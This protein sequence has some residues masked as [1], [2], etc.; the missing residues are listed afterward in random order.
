MRWYVAV[1]DIED[2]EQAEQRLQNENVTLREEI[3]KVRCR[4]GMSAYGGGDAIVAST[5]GGRA[6]EARSESASEV[7]A[8]SGTSTN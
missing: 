7:E 1:A 4:K 5:A 8:K 6:F 2:Y 3:D